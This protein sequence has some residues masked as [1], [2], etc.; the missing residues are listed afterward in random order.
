MKFLNKL[1]N[2]TTIAVIGASRDPKKVGHQIL[3][4]IIDGGFRGR[5]IPINLKE[6][7][8]L[9][10]KA[11][12]SVLKVP[13]KID[14]AIIVI[15]APAVPK[16]LA[17]CGQK[18]IENVIV[19]AAGFSEAGSKGEKLEEQ[20]AEIAKDCN[21]NL[22]GPNCL[23]IVCPYK[24]LN[25]SFARSENTPG[26][27][28]IISQ[29]GAL[30]VAILDW[31]SEKNIGLSHFV[32]IGNKTVISEIDILEYL[33]QDPRTKLIFVYIEDT[34]NGKKLMKALHDLRKPVI[35]LKGGETARGKL[36]AASHTG[37]LATSTKTFDA[38]LKQ[39]QVILSQT[40][41]EAFDTILSLYYQGAPRGNKVAIITNAGGPGIIATDELA[42]T[43][44]QLSEIKKETE[45]KLKKILPPESSLKNPIDILGDADAKRYYETVRVV[46]A[47]E[48]VDAILVLLTPQTAT[49]TKKTAQAI[50][51]IALDIPKPFF[52]SFIG[53]KRVA[54]ARKIFHKNNLPT[55]EY[56]SQAIAVLDILSK[57]EETKIATPKKI[58]ENLK[59]SIE[60][61][62][63]KKPINYSYLITKKFK[64]P[65][66]DTQIVRSSQELNY[67]AKS[68]GFP[69]VAK[70]LSRNVVHKKAAG[71]V[72]LDIDSK[73][74]L[75]IAYRELSKKFGKTASLSPYI[76]DGVEF[77]IGGK[78]D[79][80]FGPVV[81]FGIGGIYV[82]GINDITARVFPID[83]SEASKMLTEIRSKKIIEGYGD[84]KSLCK[85]KIADLIIR[86]GELLYNFPEISEID[87][88]PVKA[89]AKDIKILDSRIV[90]ES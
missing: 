40:L 88:N 39:S 80:V 77:Y 3:K 58:S 15:P 72:V 11:Y 79:P 53:G 78:K 87:F 69:L 62:L 75:K 50:S 8:I 21:I 2:P 70:T 66:V 45:R 33:A 57:A 31:T 64:L 25:A 5:A 63:E 7:R 36:A 9:A 34:P 47:D 84:F 41:E 56:P 1:F 14:L 65:I 6:D 29:S 85:N 52:T 27:L 19:I 89:T 10:K 26:K 17:E 12:S 24:N 55:F 18:K 30:G 28:S 59:K 54:R 20:I 83:K 60:N 61:I 82:Q 86:T 49:E 90:L 67:V 4:N 46:A 42:K 23:G 76:S 71:G 68:V 81:L 13:T 37:A 35:L 48:N 73:K 16:V 38:A 22:L 43:N 74:E 32:S 51:E 44:F